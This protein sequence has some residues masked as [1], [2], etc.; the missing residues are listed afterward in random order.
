MS[1]RAK[2]LAA[3]TVLGLLGI[4]PIP[5][6]TLLGFY[7]VLRRPLWFRHLIAELYAESD[8]PPSPAGSR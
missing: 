7:V 4:G 3:L 1:A 2:C 5:T 6:T 8:N